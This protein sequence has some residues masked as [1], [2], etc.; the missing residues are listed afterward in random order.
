MNSTPYFPV[1]PKLPNI[2]PPK[3]EDRILQETV[4]A[5]FRTGK[6][7]ETA[8]HVSSRSDDEIPKTFPSPAPF[9]EQG[10]LVKTWRGFG[11]ELLQ[12]TAFVLLFLET[13]SN[14]RDFSKPLP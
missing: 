9:S 8:T 6:R 3:F 10:L 1:D 12:D 5:L 7:T 4:H 11:S 2:A 14:G 13:T